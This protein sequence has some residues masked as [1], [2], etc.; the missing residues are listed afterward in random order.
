MT[1]RSALK[2]V[3]RVGCRRPTSEYWMTEGA[4]VTAVVVGVIGHVDHGKTALVRAL[5]GTDTDRLPQEKERGISIEL[6]FAHMA[7]RAGARVGAAAG[8]VA[9]VR[10]AAAAAGV[11]DLIDMPGHERFVRT[12]IS[13]ATGIDAALLVI[14]ANE[15][16]RPQTVEHVHIAGLLGLRRAVVAI[17]KTDLV[18]PAHAASV[19]DEAVRLLARSGLEAHQPVMTSVLKGSGIDAL[20]EALE[21]IATAQPPRPADGH[22]FLP[23]DRAFSITG[24]GPVVTSTLRGAALSTSDTLELLPQRQLVRVRA[25]QVHGSWV[26]SAVPG[27]RVAV[28]LRDID[29]ADLARGMTLVAPGT[30]PLSDRLTLC[31]RAV[32]SAPPLK[33]GLKLRALLGT[34]EVDTRLRLL[35]RDIL[36]PG[37]QA[38]AQLHCLEPVALPPGEHVALRLASPPQT[39]AGGRVL[40]SNTRR[41]RRNCAQALERLEDLRTLPPAELL[42]AEVRRAGPAGVTLQHLSQLSALA[43]P[44]IVELL[45]SHPVVLTTQGHVVWKTDLDD[46]LARIP[47]LLASH[48]SAVTSGAT[49]GVTHADLLTALPQTSAAVLDEALGLLRTQGLIRERGGQFT[50]PQPQQDQARARVEQDLARQIAERLRR[51]GLSPPNPSDVVTDT[52]SKRAVDRLL[53]EGVVVRAVD[54]AKGRQMLF[55]QDAIEEAQRR[56]APLLDRVPT[57]IRVTDVGVALGISRRHSMPL[58][59][60]LDTIRFTLRI[61]DRRVRATSASASTASASTASAGTAS[62]GTASAGTASVSGAPVGQAAAARSPRP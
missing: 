14:A 8:A 58:L 59:D 40:E 23:I 6:G 13:G 43:A 4:D 38:F 11:I 42:A 30:L 55:H 61:Q 53:R 60:H 45:R 29:I 33:N 12:L 2:I 19:A 20:R 3:S 48:V 9:G 7:V 1:P 34:S 26:D 41:V 39:V 49:S 50:I 52:R 24:H 47:P 17:S 57:G 36:E 16:I 21:A 28:N 44:R 5:T 37:H 32:E 25:V 15:G 35:D 46:L 18:S 22:V 54:R 56:L 31:L 62:A 51:S 10:V 27:Q